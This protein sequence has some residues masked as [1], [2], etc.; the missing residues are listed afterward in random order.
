MCLFNAQFS[1]NSDQTFID[2]WGKHLTH[3][4]WTFSQVIGGLSFL[5]VMSEETPELCMLCT[6][7]IYWSTV[8][9]KL[10][11]TTHLASL[12]KKCLSTSGKKQNAVLSPF[13]SSLLTMTPVGPVSFPG[14]VRGSI[15]HAYRSTQMTPFKAVSCV[16]VCVCVKCKCAN[17]FTKCK[18]HFCCDA[19]E[20]ISFSLH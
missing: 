9:S 19:L 1:T 11:K 13:P 3:W 8:F 5:F 17:G 12:C 15:Q 2:S 14:A 20:R 7:L 6:F 10:Y 18:F 4:G 16:C